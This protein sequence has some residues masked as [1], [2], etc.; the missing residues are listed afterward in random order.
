MR[1]IVALVRADQLHIMRWAARLGEFSRCDS[2]QEVVPVLVRTWQTLAGLIE[3]HI[4]A[5]EEICGPAVFG[6]DGRG[7][8]LARATR[9]AHEDIREII[10][11]VSLQPPGSPPWWRLAG[12]VLVAWVVQVDLEEHGPL[13]ECR[14]R[15][16][17]ALRERLAAQWRAFTE[18]HIHD[19]YPQAPPDIP[20]HQL[21]QDSRAPATVPRLAD[22]VFGPLA[23]TC[24]ACTRMLDRTIFREKEHV[25]S[26]D[27]RHWAE[28]RSELLPPPGRQPG[29]SGRVPGGEPDGKA[30][31]GPDHGGV[32]IKHM[33]EPELGSV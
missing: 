26:A 29:S 14:R 9:A 6:L 27:G 31:S 21:R 3:L 12:A 17:P 8:V 25:R 28:V 10:R 33:D 23:C 24:R 19:Q 15:A 20:T 13:A 11:E 30:V 5:D 16:D 4:S 32:Q 18:A 1:D 7:R 2:G 22:P